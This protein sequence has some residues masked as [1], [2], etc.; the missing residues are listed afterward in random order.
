MNV[1][2]FLDLD[3]PIINF[4]R[5]QHNLEVGQ[6][7]KAFCRVSSYP[8]PSYVWYR[9]NVVISNTSELFFD[10]LTD[11]DSG[12]YRCQAY[13]GILTSTSDL[14]IRVNCKFFFKR[15]CLRDL[16]YKSV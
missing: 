15:F 12:S 3:L 2:L 10:F 4:S 7:L 14:Y 13:S 16:K 1:I 11:T 9:H 5:D 6:S 8:E